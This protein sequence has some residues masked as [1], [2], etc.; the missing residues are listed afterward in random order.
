MQLFRRDSV[1]GFILL[2]FFA[3]AGCSGGSSGM[4]MYGTG[5]GGTSWQREVKFQVQGPGGITTQGNTSTI[6]FAK[7]KLLIEEA[8]ILL[9]SKE[10]VAIP[11]DA[12]KI[13]VNYARSQLTI[14]ADG[15]QVH[16]GKVN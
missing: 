5:S 7:G 9:N 3:S 16:A 11:Q 13:E 8:R 1:A 4:A 15:K 2:V 14:T 10:L 6:Q 12:K